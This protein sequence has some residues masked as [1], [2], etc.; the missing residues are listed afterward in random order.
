MSVWYHLDEN[1]TVIYLY[2]NSTELLSNCQPPLRALKG[3][4]RS[5]HPKPHLWSLLLQSVNFQV[6]Q[7][8]DWPQFIGGTPKY[9]PQHS[10]FSHCPHFMHAQVFLI[11]RLRVSLKI[12]PLCLIPI[13]TTSVGLWLLFWFWASPV[14]SSTGGDRE[15]QVSHKVED[16]QWI[17]SLFSKGSFIQYGGK[18][19]LWDGLDHWCR[20]AWTKLVQAWFSFVRWD[21][22][23]SLAAYQKT[24]P[25]GVGTAVSRGWPDW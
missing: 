6:S 11:W 13:T 22:S 8:S 3:T 5:E 10:P 4:S 25:K 24:L 17:S 23:S 1:S 19:F 7:T 18:Q 20:M 16:K 21:W 15:S 12:C 2:V 14:F 9:H